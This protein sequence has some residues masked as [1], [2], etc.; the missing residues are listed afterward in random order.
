MTGKQDDDEARRLIESAGMPE[1]LPPYLSELETIMLS[2][3]AT[4]LVVQH[5]KAPP[6]RHSGHPEGGAGTGHGT[7]HQHGRRDPR[8]P[9]PGRTVGHE[10]T[11]G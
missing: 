7:T 4:R 11:E 2:W 6:G 10:P 5:L 1:P 3:L 8:H 9:L